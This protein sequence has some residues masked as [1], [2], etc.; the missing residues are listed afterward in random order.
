MLIHE[1]TAAECAAL[2]R[3]INLGRLGCSRFDQPYVVP[4]HFSFAE[5]ENCIYAFSTLGQKIEWMRRNSKVC[6]EVEEISDK[7]H[8]STVVVVGRYEELQQ[9]LEDADA[10]QRAEQLFGQRHEWWLPAAARLTTA[11]RAH[12]VLY[13]IRIDRMTGRRAGR[14]RNTPPPS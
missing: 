3:R 4:I 10:R 14:D 2:L 9:T 5:G 12:V 7:D 8:W 13:R 6:L 11:E 1:L